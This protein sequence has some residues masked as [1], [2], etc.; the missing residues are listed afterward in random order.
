MSAKSITAAIAA[1]VALA[2]GAVSP[3]LAQEQIT[4]FETTSSDVRA[5]GHPD[6][7]TSFTLDEPGVEEAAMNVIFNAPE[8]VFG[9]INA[10]TNCIPSD[11]ALDKC[12]PNSQIGLITVHAN[13]SGDQNFLLGTAPMYDV[14][15][16][17]DQTALIQF[18]VP[19][20]DIPISIPVTVRTGDD[21]GLRFKVSDITQLTPL[22][23]VNLIIWGFPASELHNAE[24]FPAGS[25][26]KPAGCPGLEDASCNPTPTKP[27]I[28]NQPFT[29]NPTHCS[30]E[31]L[32]TE[33]LVETY[34][35]P[36]NF[37]RALGAYPE[38]EECE[39]ET[40]KP[41]LQ[42]RPTT[43]ET[44]SAAGLDLNL[45]AKQ[46]EGFAASPSE[47]KSAVV[48][49]PEPPEL[50]SPCATH[51]DDAVGAAQLPAAHV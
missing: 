19:T 11:F 8:G 17:A 41:L 49:F 14:S 44:D 24:R 18:N 5:G 23:S 7:T 16:Q 2:L 36:G 27:S 6:L 12:P 30:G 47:I 37:S 22:A 48:T 21:F 43:D 1:S 10:V 31:E 29:D 15:P 13:Y 46:F 34:Q 40:F 35:D 50:H 25:P 39:R 42:G 45:S 4:S 32:A 51:V 3:A 26:G 33:L 20:L 9:N 28:P 38:V